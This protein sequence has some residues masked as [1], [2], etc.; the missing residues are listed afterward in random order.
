MN[1]NK[2][3]TPSPP[4]ISKGALVRLVRSRKLWMVV[5]MLIYVFSVSGGVYDIIRN[6]PIYSYH[7]QGGGGVRWFHPAPNVQFVAEGF[8]TGI[9]NLIT[10]MA[11]VI[12]IQA[13]PNL[14]DPKARSTM[15]M[16]ASVVFVYLF[17]QV[18][19]LYRTKNRWYRPSW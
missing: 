15:A 13:A 14:K 5:S 19:S 18:M 7:P 2:F 12:L 1:P 11:G 6:P 3:A 8:I 9:M 17:Y 16:T 4:S 10:G